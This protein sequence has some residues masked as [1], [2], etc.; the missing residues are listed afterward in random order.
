M[1]PP[2]QSDLL[3]DRGAHFRVGIAHALHES[4]DR[5]GFLQPAE[6]LNHRQPHGVVIILERGDKMLDRFIRSLGRELFNGL[7]PR[8]R[9]LELQL[10]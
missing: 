9:V 7:P 8:L 10:L 6:S 4:G 5:S 1:S 3:F 2:Y